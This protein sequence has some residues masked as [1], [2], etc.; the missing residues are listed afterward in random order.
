MANALDVALKKL[1]KLGYKRVSDAP[2]DQPTEADM[3]NEDASDT[4]T[5]TLDPVQLSERRAF[6]WR[7]HRGRDDLWME[8]ME[9]RGTDGV[10]VKT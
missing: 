9:L 7:P 1:E 8:I 3:A 6:W 4:W 2:P 5:G 10:K